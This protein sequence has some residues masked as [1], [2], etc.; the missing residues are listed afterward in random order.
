MGKN[1]ISES[2]S[3]DS[4]SSLGSKSGSGSGSDPDQAP[5][6]PSDPNTHDADAPLLDS[7]E[8]NQH[9]INIEQHTVVTEEGF[10]AGGLGVSFFQSPLPS[11]KS[12]ISTSESNEAKRKKSRSASL[13]FWGNRP[14]RKYR[15]LSNPLLGMEVGF[16]EAQ[17]LAKE[18]DNLRSSGEVRLLNFAYLELKKSA[19]VLGY[20]SYSKVYAGEFRG[21]PV[22]IKMLFTPDLNPEVREIIMNICL[23]ITN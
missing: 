4:R 7:L 1:I 6:G 5:A 19:P 13:S 12:V 23:S 10:A 3:E 20:G 14:S 21:R 15:A 18:V 11:V 16:N 2:M 22:A 8:R 17:E 9:D